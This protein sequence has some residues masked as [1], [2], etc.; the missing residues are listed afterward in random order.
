MNIHTNTIPPT[1]DTGKT[2]KQ[3]QSQREKKREGAKKKE[4]RGFIKLLRAVPKLYTW[5]SIQYYVEKLQKH[6]C[7][8]T[9][10]TLHPTDHW[11][12]MCLVKS[13][14]AQTIACNRLIVQL[15]VWADIRFNRT[16]RTSP[17]IYRVRPNVW[18]TLLHEFSQYYWSELS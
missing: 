4:E 2:N 7:G 14:S 11:F 17:C 12:K 13:G 15:W 6:H 16:I 5:P 18:T 3:S 10:P 1:E 8:P 9:N